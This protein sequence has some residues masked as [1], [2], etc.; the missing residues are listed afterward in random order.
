[1]YL[2]VVDGDE[3]V[4]AVRD[5]IFVD[6]LARPLTWPFVAHVTVADECS[7]ERIVAA[8][9]ALAGYTTEMSF[10]RVHLLQEGPGRV[11]G[12]VADF[13]F[14]AP[15]TIGRGG[16]PVELTVT[17]EA[18]PSVRAFLR[19]AAGQHEP[20][21]I[22]ARRE[23]RI[24]GVARGW[25]TAESAQLSELVVADGERQL[26]TEDHLV[27]AF[28]SWAAKRGVWRHGGG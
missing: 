15:A 9:E 3:A 6:P 27:A 16:L 17:D 20:V 18:D 12:P 21:T 10:E 25:A 19:G 23:G 13:P 28:D 2:P 11:W 4:H 8:Q 22:T 5:K 24:V 1:L 7:P 14:E 26:G